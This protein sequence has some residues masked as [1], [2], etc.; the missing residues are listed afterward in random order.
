MGVE[1]RSCQKIK[2]LQGGTWTSLHFRISDGYEQLNIYV[3]LVLMLYNV[4][5][6]T[7]K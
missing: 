4:I 1:S 5:E 2:F 3:Q 7:F 6:Q